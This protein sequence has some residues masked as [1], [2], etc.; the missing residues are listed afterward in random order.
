MQGLGEGVARHDLVRI[1]DDGPR[2][3]WRGR[4]LVPGVL[5]ARGEGAAGADHVGKH[6]LRRLDLEVKVPSGAVAGHRD[7]PVDRA[8][9]SGESARVVSRLPQA[10]FVAARQLL[11]LSYLQK[12]AQ[13]S[14]TAERQG[15]TQPA[16]LCIRGLASQIAGRGGRGRKRISA[17]AQPRRHADGGAA[18][19]A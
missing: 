7:I 11:A 10:V 9:G 19:G 5:H 8:V 3:L 16:Q 4:P 15:G 14:L 17:R 1:E 13:R 12:R 6:G 2:L 18:G